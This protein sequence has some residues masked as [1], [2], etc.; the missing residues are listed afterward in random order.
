MTARSS[1]DKASLF[2]TL[3]QEGIEVGEVEGKRP[4]TSIFDERGDSRQVP[5]QPLNPRVR[6]RD[7]RK[8]SLFDKKQH[9][10]LAFHQSVLSDGMIPSLKHVPTETLV[11]QLD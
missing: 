3:Q 6:K 1:K 4:K 2:E 11:S 7:I 9:M 5:S 8:E 10:F